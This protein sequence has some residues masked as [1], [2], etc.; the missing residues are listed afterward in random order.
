MNNLT[1]RIIP[2]DSWI[3]DKEWVMDF[4]CAE[5]REVSSFNKANVGPHKNEMKKVNITTL[6]KFIEN[7]KIVID[8]ICLIKIDVEWFEREVIKGMDTVLKNGNMKII[9][10]ILRENDKKE[11]IINL[12][13]RYWFKYKNINRANFLFYR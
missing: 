13:K 11:E 10:E 2:V 8:K 12:L 1:D 5:V 7:K 9:M 3:G 6:D 4:F